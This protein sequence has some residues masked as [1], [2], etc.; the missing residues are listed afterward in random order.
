MPAAPTHTPPCPCPPLIG[1][2]LPP[3]TPL[4][5]SSSQPVGPPPPLQSDML[6]T[7]TPVRSVSSSAFS[8]SN[9]LRTPWTETHV[10][11]AALVVATSAPP[12]LAPCRLVVS[13]VIWAMLNERSSS[14][15]LLRLSHILFWF[16]S[17]IAT[18]P[19]A[20]AAHADPLVRHDMFTL[21]MLRGPVLPPNL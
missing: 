18:A 9:F 15:L 4:P 3:P 10:R 21:P 11:A 8:P 6:S 17:S 5:S 20:A 12:S 16:F 2:P 14:H 19:T 13:V 1:C 7:S